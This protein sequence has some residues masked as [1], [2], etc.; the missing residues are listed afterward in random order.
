MDPSLLNGDLTSEAIDYE[1]M[2]LKV[3]R[4]FRMA[5]H[6]RFFAELAR[7]PKMVKFSKAIVGDDIKLIQSMALCK[8][9]GSGAKRWHQD[10]AYF[11]LSPS[12][13]LAFWVALED[14]NTENGC[15]H[16][17][18]KS[19]SSGIVPHAIPTDVAIPQGQEHAF[20]SLQN[21]PDP[22]QVVAVPLEEGDALVFHG[23]LF[24]YTPPNKTTKRRRAIQYHYASS[25]CV[26]KGSSDYWYYRK[27]EM[28]ICG[29]DFG[30][31]FI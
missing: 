30:E 17:V 21:T 24:H 15:M 2:E 28:L 16:V 7:H 12:K 27:A 26:P 5:V 6:D 25:Q 20:F 19:H 1:A 23:E 3:R 4:Y 9:P 29:K 14:T 18:P 31:G 13:V 8:P 10:N 22:N 11:C